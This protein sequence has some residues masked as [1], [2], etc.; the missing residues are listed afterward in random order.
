MLRSEE[1]REKLMQH[2]QRL[3]GAKARKASVDELLGY[4][5]GLGDLTIQQIEIAVD[6]AIE[7]PGPWPL[8]AASVKNMAPTLASLNRSKES[9]ND[10]PDCYGTGFKIVPRPDGHGKWAERCGCRGQK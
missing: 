2:V 8:D 10:C 1:D 4:E 3:F 7:V 9:R 6:S 5:S